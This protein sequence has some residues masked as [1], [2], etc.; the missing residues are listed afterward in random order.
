MEIQEYPDG[1]MPT[2]AVITLK[3]IQTWASQN[4]PC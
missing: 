2:L 4:T 1:V 3:N